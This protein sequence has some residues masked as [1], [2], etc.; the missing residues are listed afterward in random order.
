M[1]GPIDPEDFFP[2][3]GASLSSRLPQSQVIRPA[4]CGGARPRNAKRAWLSVFDAQPKMLS[5]EPD[6]NARVSSDGMAGQVLRTT[7]ELA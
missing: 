1:S 2:L 7:A 5:L 6:D 4:G 3:N